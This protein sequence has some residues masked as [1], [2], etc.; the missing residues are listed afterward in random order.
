MEA[1]HQ[2]LVDG[3]ARFLNLGLAFA[4]DDDRMGI[5]VMQV[6]DGAVSAGYLGGNDV[7]W[8]SGWQGKFL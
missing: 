6:R 8:P 5:W 3:F 7:D 1:D 2:R 4:R